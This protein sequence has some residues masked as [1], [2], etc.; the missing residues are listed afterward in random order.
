[1]K[2]DIHE[3][4]N[5]TKKEKIKFLKAMEL[6]ELIWNSEDFK[7]AVL[8]YK[9]TY[10]LVP[11]QDIYIQFIS[12]IDKINKE[13]DQDLDIF[14]KMYYSWN[15]VI[16][17]TYPSTAMTWIN[18]RFFKIMS[19]ASIIGNVTHEYMHKLGYD[20]PFRWTTTRKDSVPYAYGYI[21]TNIG[22]KF[23]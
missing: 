6:G 12:G 5:F 9:F 17:F 16:G 21:T 18:R 22:N 10:T 2:T 23:L 20:H 13:R 4:I 3:M 8:N 19:I 1:M 7:L 11:P 14:I 15:S